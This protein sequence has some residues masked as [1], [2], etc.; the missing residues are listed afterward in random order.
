MS[1]A[2]PENRATAGFAT[3][4][5]GRGPIGVL[6][7]MGPLATVDFLGKLIAE[8]EAA[9]DQD[10]VPT[11][12]WNVPQIPDRQ[13]ALAGRGPS[14]L[15]ALIEGVDRLVGAGA[16]AI[17]IPCNTAHLW[18]D[19]IAAASPVPV[20]HI[21]AATLAALA[22]AVEPGVPIGLIATRG[23]VEGGLYQ[24]RL[25]AAGHPAVVATDDEFD[26]LFTPGCYAV[27]RNAIAEGGALLQASAER[28]LAR[29]ARHLILACTEVPLA[30]E[31]IGSPRV[32]VSTD[33]TRALARA[34]RDHWLAGRV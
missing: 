10:H 3:P 12:T 19:D 5:L 32:S 4:G 16:S 23:L 11:V 9:R 31:A 6:G 27:K 13:A 30:L 24:N 15:P 1:T 2:A 7:G 22:S 17:V 21:A 28:L 25:A 14:P 33:A 8:T 29:G 20:I 34:A 26:D 18:F